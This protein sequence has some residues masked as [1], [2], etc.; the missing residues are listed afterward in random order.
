MALEKTEMGRQALQC[1]DQNLTPR[2]RQILILAN[3]KNSRTTI[4]LLFHQ[5][6]GVKSALE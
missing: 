5:D 6:I 2:E 4:E 1:R 3:G